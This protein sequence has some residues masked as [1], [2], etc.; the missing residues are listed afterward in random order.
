MDNPNRTWS[1]NLPENTVATVF[2]LP[3]VVSLRIT[4]R[5][6][7]G[8]VKSIE[9]TAPDGTVRSLS[10]ETFR[11]RAKLKSTWI[12]Q[13]AVAGTPAPTPLP[14]GID[15]ATPSPTPSPT[16]SLSPSPTD[17]ATATPSPSPT[18][19][20]T[21]PAITLTAPGTATINVPFVLSGVTSAAPQGATV[22]RQVLAN[23]SW[24]NRGTALALAVDGTWQMNVTSD[25]LSTFTYRAVLRDAS[26]KILAVS[27]TAAV[28]V[29]NPR[30]SISITA[31]SSVTIGEPFVLSGKAAVWPGGSVAQR[32]VLDN[33]QWEN[34]GATVPIAADGSWKMTATAPSSEQSMEFR[35]LLV[36]DGRI[37]AT[38]P[39][40]FIEF[41]R[42]VSTPSASPTPT[43]TATEAA[44][45]T[46]TLPRK[47]KVGAAFVMK[48]TAKP[49][50]KGSTVIR[51]VLIGSTWTNRGTA[52]PVN[53]DG[54][55]TMKATAPT[56]AQAMKFRYYVVSAGK[57]IVS[58]SVR[59]ITFV[60]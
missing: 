13:I 11:S 51:Q 3:D 53:A 52:V 57:K 21:A 1:A 35:A 49:V 41:V 42:V 22:Q 16:S 5:T 25:A 15:S 50:P 31:H 2:G 14:T 9:A 54:T 39:V 60:K 36:K 6:M 30:P 33:G 10:G 44:A 23:G 56:R 28:V 37:V 47:V 4:G 27:N 43:P 48:G 38:S 55:W 12:W 20:A 40:Q 45:I 29:G 7:G 24:G 58:S 32:Q 18:P 59:A 19:T 46:V 26:G 34:R 8:G 17:S